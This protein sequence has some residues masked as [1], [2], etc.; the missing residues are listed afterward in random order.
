MLEVLKFMLWISWKLE[1]DVWPW[2]DLEFDR[3]FAGILRRKL[4]TT[5]IRSKIVWRRFTWSYALSS[6]IEY[7]QKGDHILFSSVKIV[8]FSLKSLGEIESCLKWKVL[9]ES[10]RLKRLKVTGPEIQNEKNGRSWGMNVDVTKRTV[11]SML[12]ADVGDQMCCWQVWEVVNKSD[13]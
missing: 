6:I 4:Y 7:F 5:C 13:H 1:L 10:G 12:V 11:K 9:N 8:Y 3:Y 2:I